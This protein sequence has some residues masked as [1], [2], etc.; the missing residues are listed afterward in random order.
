M[1]TKEE[2]RKAC[3]YL[4]NCAFQIFSDLSERLDKDNE[5][6]GDGYKFL[7]RHYYCTLKQ[8]LADD[9]N[10]ESGATNDVKE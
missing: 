5:I 2:K 4:Y 9:L 1:M 8:Y 3:E 10:K 7:V 6:T